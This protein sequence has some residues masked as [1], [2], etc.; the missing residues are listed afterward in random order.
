MTKRDKDDDEREAQEETVSELSTKADEFLLRLSR[1]SEVEPEIAS[2]IS[3]SSRRLVVADQL[4]P[5]PWLPT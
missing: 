5:D 1:R 3:I 2:D 4:P